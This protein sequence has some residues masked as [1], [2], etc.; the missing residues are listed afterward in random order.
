MMSGWLKALQGFDAPVGPPDRFPEGFFCRRPLR[1]FP[2]RAAG[3]MAA[4]GILRF[5]EPAER[6]RRR[7]AMREK[8]TQMLFRV[9]DELNQFRPREEHLKKD[10][11]TPLAGGSGELDA[12]CGRGGTREQALRSAGIRDRAGRCI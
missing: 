10:L 7:A 8:I 9:L 3:C 11:E 6:W 4:T 5:I 2:R 12:S 1:V